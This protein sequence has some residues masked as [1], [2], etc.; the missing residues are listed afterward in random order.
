LGLIKIGM[1]IDV[2]KRM[3]ALRVGS[4][5]TLKVMGVIRTRDPVT[6]E[7]D[8]HAQ[9][10]RA[11]HHGEWFSPIRR[12]TDFIRHNAM[13]HDQAYA[14]WCSSVFHRMTEPGCDVEEVYE[15]LLLKHQ[16]EKRPAA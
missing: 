13:A 2:A 11:R 9:F 12:L 14:I 5:D 1:A 8:L 16:A 15:R 10:R 3:K 4:P 6:L 7:R